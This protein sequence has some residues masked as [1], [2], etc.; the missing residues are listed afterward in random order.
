MLKLVWTQQSNGVKY[1]VWDVGQT[2]K[3]ALQIHIYQRNIIQMNYLTL[4]GCNIYCVNLKIKI[5][6]FYFN[7]RTLKHSL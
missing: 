2:R 5:Y 3:L 7:N 1:G 4:L 6:L